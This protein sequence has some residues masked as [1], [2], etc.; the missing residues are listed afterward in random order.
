M[1][2]IYRHCQKLYAQ[3]NTLAPKFSR[4]STNVKVSLFKTYCTPLYTAHLWSSYKKSSMHRLQVAY[5]D[6]MRILLKKPRGGSASEMFVTAGVRTFKA[7]LRNLMFKFM[8]RLDVSTNGI[9]VALSS[10]LMSSSRYTSRL[11]VHWLK[12]LCVFPVG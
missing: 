11:R 9:I 2:H 8:K 7:L 3:A 10:P 5:N 6:A 1:N 12:C 4:C